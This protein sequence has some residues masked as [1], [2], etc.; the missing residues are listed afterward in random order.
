MATA[1]PASFLKQP[2]SPPPTGVTSNFAHPESRASVI[3]IAAGICLTF[4]LVFTALRFYAKITIMKEVK[5]D[6]G[7]SL[8]SAFCG[9]D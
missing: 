6:D 5:W 9:L 4:I 1:D 3:Y 2:L 8:Q 7:E